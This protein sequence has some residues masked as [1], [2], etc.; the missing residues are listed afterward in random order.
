MHLGTCGATARLLTWVRV[1]HVIR[2]GVEETLSTVHDGS[3]YAQQLVAVT[4]SNFTKMGGKVVSQDAIAPTDVDMHPVLARIAAD[5][6]DVLYMPIFVAA[7]AQLLRQSKETPGLEHTVLFGGGSLLASGSIERT[8]TEAVEVAATPE[9]G[10]GAADSHREG[11]LPFACVYVEARPK[12]GHEGTPID[13]YVVEDDA[14]H[15]L[16]TFKKQHEAI[17]WAKKNGHS[18]LVARVRHQNDKTR[19]EY[20]RSAAGLIKPQLG[21]R[22]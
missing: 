4:A 8:N 9:Q 11:Q 12:G 20:W 14:D 19:L 3:P 13:G 18:P 1:G 16:S 21:K 10:N 15:E 22:I 7:A 2:A 6:P 17:E 5:K